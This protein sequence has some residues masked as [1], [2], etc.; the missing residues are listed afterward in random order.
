MGQP[1][2][3]AT[4]DVSLISAYFLFFKPAPWWQYAIIVRLIRGHTMEPEREGR[5]GP[6]AQVLPHL[7][8]PH[9]FFCWRCLLSFETL[10]A[11]VSRYCL[12]LPSAP[13][14]RQVHAQALLNITNQRSKP[15]FL[16]KY[17]RN[18]I[19]HLYFNKPSFFSPCDAQV[20]P[21]FLHT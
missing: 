15:P 2:P 6:Y 1:Q 13:S 10:Q 12:I 20:A 5:L 3:S 18:L 7:T 11:F 4:L 19:H 17:P 9:H 21:P 8:V 14:Y 16:S